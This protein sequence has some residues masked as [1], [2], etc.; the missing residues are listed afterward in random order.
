M[1]PRLLM[2]VLAFFVIG[3]VAAV[4][5][6]PQIQSGVVR[7]GKALIG[8]PFTLVNQKGERVSD[9][10]FRGK[11]MLVVFGYTY[12][13]DICPAELQLMAT[14]MDKLGVKADQVAPIFITIDPKRDTIEQIGPYVANF[15]P[16]IV[17]LTGTEEE[18]RAAASAYRVFYSK[19]EGDNSPDAYLMDHS[20][21]LYLMDPNGEYVTHFPYGVTPEKLAESISK[22]IG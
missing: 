1:S 9:T 16:R 17:G 15:S 4:T 18:I 14:A 10:D 3:A 21:F 19:A 13:P 2:I 11:H 7:T 12:C 6:Q 8:G 20:T 5:L 22:A